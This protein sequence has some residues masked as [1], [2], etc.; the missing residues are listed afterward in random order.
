M[1]EGT[2][3]TKKLKTTS[4]IE[5]ATLLLKNGEINNTELVNK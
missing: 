3:L 1:N 5:L 2:I 4:K